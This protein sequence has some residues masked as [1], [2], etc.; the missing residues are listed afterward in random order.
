V[1]EAYSETNKCIP[2]SIEKGSI[3]RYKR[4]FKLLF[5]LVQPPLVTP[6]L[7]K[8]LFTSTSILNFYISL[9]AVNKG[10]NEHRFHFSE[11]KETI[12]NPKGLQ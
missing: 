12:L 10:Y 3:E 6:K 11:Q 5:T 1:E 8:L 2:T 9:I 4:R 7:A